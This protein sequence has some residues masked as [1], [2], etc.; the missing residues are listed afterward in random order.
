MKLKKIEH[1]Q[2][3]CTLLENFQ[4]DTINLENVWFDCKID[5]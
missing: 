5:M 2:L 4:L 1:V 3:E